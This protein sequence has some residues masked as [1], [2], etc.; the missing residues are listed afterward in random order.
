VATEA[1]KRQMENLG[2]LIIASGQAWKRL[3]VTETT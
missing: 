1:R 3:Y 2:L